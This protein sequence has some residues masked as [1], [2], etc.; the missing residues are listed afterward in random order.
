MG[1]AID[2]REVR[3]AIL[4]TIQYMGVA[5]TEFSP[6]RDVYEQGF[7]AT[8]AGLNTL[9]NN[10][11]HIIYPGTTVCLDLPEV[12]GNSNAYK[13]ALQAGVP[14]DKLQFVL[15]PIDSMEKTTARGA[16]GYTPE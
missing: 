11:K 5:V 10:G 9:Y 3:R 8:I 2:Q 15:T 1:G 16:S 14:Q 13:R 4:G 6:A 7:V 12:R